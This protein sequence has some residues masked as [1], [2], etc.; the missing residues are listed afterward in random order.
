MDRD[1]AKTSHSPSKIFYGDKEAYADDVAVYGQGMA[2]NAINIAEN[3]AS[4]QELQFS[5]K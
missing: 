3:W 2:K 4:E 5:S 1:F